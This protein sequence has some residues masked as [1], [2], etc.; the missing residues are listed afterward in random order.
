MANGE[1]P[2]LEKQ[3]QKKEITRLSEEVA[4][5][6]I[7]MRGLQSRLEQ[8]ELELATAREQ[9]EL[10]SVSELKQ[11][12]SEMRD[13]VRGV[14][15]SGERSSK[16]TLQELKATLAEREL[17]IESRMSEQLGE[18]LSEIDRSIRSATA[19]P[20]DITEE[21]TDV[22]VERLFDHEDEMETNLGQLEVE[23]LTSKSGISDSLARLKAARGGAGVKGH[24]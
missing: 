6:D 22:L 15:E 3:E 13:L 14:A 9:G 2:A 11:E 18:T 23:E 19:Q 24:E 10:A 12:L 7:A 20:I 17:N 16:S 8:K 4:Q 5:A 1:D 21:A